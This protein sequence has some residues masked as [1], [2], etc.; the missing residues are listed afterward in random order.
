MVDDGKRS[1]GN[2][3]IILV[4]R[5]VM[6]KSLLLSGKDVIIDDTNFSSIH[7]KYLK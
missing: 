2:E 6:A 4:M 7:E 3:K 1:R 5:N